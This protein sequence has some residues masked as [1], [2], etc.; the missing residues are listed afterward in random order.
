ML[1]RRLQSARRDVSSTASEI[2]FLCSDRIW[3][4]EETSTLRGV[5]VHGRCFDRD[6]RPQLEPDETPPS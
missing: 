2:C 1:D 3:P 6:V 5:P 4:G